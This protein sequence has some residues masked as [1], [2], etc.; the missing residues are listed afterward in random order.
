MKNIG[1]IPARLESKRF[2]QKL[3]KDVLGKPLIQRTYE[4]ALRCHLLDELYIAT[5]SPLIEEAA[6]SFSAKVIKT[7]ACD[8]GTERIACAIDTLKETGPKDV[9]INIQGDHPCIMPST[10]DMMIMPFN[11]QETLVTTPLMLIKDLKKANSPNVV[12][13]VFDK[14]KRALYF[15]RSAIPHNATEY[16][17]HLGIY[18][19]RKEFLMKLKDLPN[20][21]MQLKEDLEQLKILEHGY[22]I[23]TVIVDDSEISVDIPSDLINLRRYLCTQNLSL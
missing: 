10:I 14:N 13:C 7:K 1:V 6:K 21:P 16:Y 12:K 11:D 19:Y 2:P 15:S 4:N 18:A 9:I 23:H 20:T 3:L 22:S 17:Q 8:N 5:D